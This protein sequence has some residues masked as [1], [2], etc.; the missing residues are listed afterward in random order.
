MT[1]GS[2]GTSIRGS[3]SH[4]GARESHKRFILIVFFH[5][6]WVFSTIFSLFLYVIWTLCCTGNNSFMT[7]YQWFYWTSY[8]QFCE[9]SQPVPGPPK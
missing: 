3:E 7:V 1:E 6:S 2:I 9:R 5:F 8:S 4:E